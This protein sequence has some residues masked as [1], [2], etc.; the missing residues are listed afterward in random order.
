MTAPDPGSHPHITGHPGISGGEPLIRG[1][2]ITVQRIVE[3][4]RAG[5]SVEGILEAYPHLTPAQ[6]HAALS[7]YYDHQA[8][9]DQ[10]IEES[11]PERVLARNNLIAK[12]IMPG[13]YEVHDAAGRWP[14]PALGNHHPHRAGNPR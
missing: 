8:E 13:A 2:R 9:I 6:V 12:E 7:Y 1:T 11:K 5:E 4:T 14:A 10:L 3:M